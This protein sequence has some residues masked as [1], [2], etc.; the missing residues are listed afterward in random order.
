MHFSA[1]R[2]L[3]TV[4]QNIEKKPSRNFSEPRHDPLRTQPVFF[5]FFYS[6]A[7]I[8]SLVKAHFVK[9]VF[10]HQAPGPLPCELTSAF[11]IMSCCPVRSICTRLVT[12]TCII[13]PRS[14]Y[15][16]TP[17]YPRP[18]SLQL[19]R[20]CSLVKLAKSH[21]L[22]S[23]RNDHRC[24]NKRLLAPR[25]FVPITMKMEVGRGGLGVFVEHVG[26]QCPAPSDPLPPHPQLTTPLELILRKSRHASM[27]DLAAD[28][29]RMLVHTPV[30]IML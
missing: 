3:R 29:I 24:S 18:F 13:V 30:A 11:S 7:R 25:I 26:V 14:G 17:S 28:P 5:I 1:K 22:V 2:L 21:L 19:I 10:A 12:P 27:V 16:S 9:M 6:L 4:Q 8:Q 20:F 15:A 23:A